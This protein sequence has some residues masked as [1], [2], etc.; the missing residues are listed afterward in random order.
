M[1]RANEI[2]QTPA[3]QPVVV[4]SS[5]IRCLVCQVHAGFP[6]RSSRARSPE[7]FIHL[8]FCHGTE[9]FHGLY[10]HVVRC[11]FE[12]NLTT[13]L[14]RAASSFGVTAWPPRRK[15]ALMAASSVRSSSLGKRQ[16]HDEPW[17]A[18]V[19]LVSLLATLAGV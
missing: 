9:R 3:P 16:A 8:P 19:E 5:I 7:H 4:C 12:D 15:E 6:P 10:N 11:N 14:V 2:D 18:V 17:G 1:S 13:C